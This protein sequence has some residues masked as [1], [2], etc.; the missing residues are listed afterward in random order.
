M[1]TGGHGV[2]GCSGLAAQLL[3]KAGRILV[4]PATHLTRVGVAIS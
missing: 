4:T 2:G 3:E 1:L